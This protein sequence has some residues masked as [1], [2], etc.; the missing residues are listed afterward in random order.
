MKGGKGPFTPE[1]SIKEETVASLRIRAQQETRKLMEEVDEEMKADQ[2]R[3]I[4]EAE[5][6]LGRKKEKRREE[7]Q[8]TRAAA[9][10]KAEL[11]L[12]ENMR[13]RFE[14]IAKANKENPRKEA[15]E[16]GLQARLLSEKQ[17]MELMEAEL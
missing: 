8:R 14:E 13:P 15:A 6:M 10:E 3:A 4:R 12:K 1:A 11:L 7:F 2:E 17:A 9:K 16:E 5:V